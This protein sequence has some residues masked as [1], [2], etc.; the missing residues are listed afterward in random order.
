M[1]SKTVSII[2]DK[3]DHRAL[4]ELAKEDGRNLSSFIRKVISDYLDNK[5]DG[6]NEYRG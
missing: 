3:K 4:M 2:F 5:G 1:T 6:E